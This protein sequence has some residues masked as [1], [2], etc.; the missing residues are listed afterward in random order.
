MTIIKYYNKLIKKITRVNRLTKEF[1]TLSD[2]QKDIWKNDNIAI[3][4][5]I[6]D[7][8]EGI[9]NNMEKL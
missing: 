6:K 2:A 1:D 5:V 3:A 7:W 4:K 8:Y 9:K